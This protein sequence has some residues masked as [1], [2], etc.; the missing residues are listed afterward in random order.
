[1]AVRSRVY[2]WSRCSCLLAKRTHSAS[3]LLDRNLSSIVN[4]IGEICNVPSAVVSLIFDTP[5]SGWLLFSHC[6]GSV[7]RHTQ[8]IFE[9]IVIYCILVSLLLTKHFCTVTESPFTHPPRL[10]LVVITTSMSFRGAYLDVK[11]LHYTGYWIFHPAIK[12]C[13]H[14]STRIRQVHQ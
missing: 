3:F 12:R 8:H 10:I 1:M 14:S 7:L 11:L 13:R 2:E 6:L 4:N 5:V 9:C